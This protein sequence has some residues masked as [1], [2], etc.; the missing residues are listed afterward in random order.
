TTTLADGTYTITDLSAGDYTVTPTLAG[1][2]FDP[3]SQP[4]HV[5]WPSGNATDIDFEVLFSISGK[6]ADA[7][8]N[9][10]EGVEIEVTGQNLGDTGNDTTAADGTYT[11]TGLRADTYDVALTKPPGSFYTFSPPSRDDVRV[12]VFRGSAPDTDFECLFPITGTVTRQDN[13]APLDDVVVTADGPF[14]ITDPA[15]VYTITGVTGGTRTVIPALANFTFVPASRSVDATVP[16]QPDGRVEDVD[17]EGVP[18]LFS[19]SG[20]VAMSGPGDFTGLDVTV[21]ATQGPSTPPPVAID[22]VTGIYTIS[23]LEAVTIDESTTTA[24]GTSG[25]TTVVDASLSRP[26]GFWDGATLELQ[27]G[28]FAGEQR[29]VVTFVAGVFTV[30]PPFAG[31]VLSGTQYRVFSGYKITP[32]SGTGLAVFDP[33]FRVVPVGP[34]QTGVNFTAF[35]LFTGPFADGLQLVGVPYTPMDLNADAADVFGI[36]SIWRWNPAGAPPQYVFYPSSPGSPIL[37]VRPGNGF[38]VAFPSGPRPEVPGTPAPVDRNFV[39]PLL[40]EW[41]MLANPFTTAFAWNTVVQSSTFVDDFAWVYVND[42]VSAGYV[43][44][45]DTPTLNTLAVVQPYQGFWQRVQ[46]GQVGAT[47]SI[48]PPSTIIVQGGP[49][50]KG[51]SAFTPEKPT[52]RA[53]VTG[54]WVLQVAAEAGEIADKCNYI[55]VGDATGLPSA[56]MDNP[57]APSRFVD[58]YFPGEAVGEPGR[59]LATDIR[60]AGATSWD[61]V[62]ATDL[63]N[64]DVA[65]SLPNV[66]GLPKD[67]QV[68]LT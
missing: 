31:Q 37:R 1:S 2:T 45:T 8:D 16:A 51:E 11:I 15:G 67:L 27:S 54:G 10:L 49:G 6:V 29:T 9:G 52:E 40:G 19:I 60:P 50:A 66:A 42:G 39:I 5:D 59:R 12:D 56:R 20:V 18:I 23:G 43:L 30:D 58:V 26:D 36:P 44:V 14:D 62:V 13:G 24:N 48:P 63:V 4:V 46:P 68:T 33:P 3:P 25:G 35:R 17:F 7:E 55:G 21:E 32:T 57:P 38:F 61:F 47:I 53:A 64:S 41:N 22:P 28:A 34:S 65:V